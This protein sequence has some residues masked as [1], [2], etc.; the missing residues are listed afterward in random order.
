MSEELVEVKPDAEF[1]DG[2]RE[3]VDVGGIEVGVLNI[4]GNY[5][6]LQNR[7]LHDGG[8]VL[9]GRTGNKLE[10]EFVEPGTRVEK[11]YGDDHIVS[12][13]WHGWSYELETGE[14]IAD[15]DIC[16]PTYEVVVEDGTVY[17]GGRK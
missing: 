2:D 12:C 9:T 8:P 16:L 10:G 4:D 7:C 5:Y 17:V 14:N 15:S 1:T 11:Y 13:P 6:A 3:F